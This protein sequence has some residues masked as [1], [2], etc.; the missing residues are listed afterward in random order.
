MQHSLLRHYVKIRREPVQTALDTWPVLG[1]ESTGDLW[2]EIYI[3]FKA[4]VPDII[5][6]LIVLVWTIEDYHYLA[7][8]KWFLF[9]VFRR[10]LDWAFPTS[11]SLVNSSLIICLFF[12]QD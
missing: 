10:P 6:S 9:L 1:T 8:I 2:V 5:F 7:S 4:V 12:N 3:I 11:N